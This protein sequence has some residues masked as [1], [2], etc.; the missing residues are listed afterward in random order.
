MSDPVL[1][2]PNEQ[3]IIDALIDTWCKKKI[4]HKKII[5]KV[6]ALRGKVKKYLLVVNRQ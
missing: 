3:K 2:E 6:F 1:Q 5:L 4:D